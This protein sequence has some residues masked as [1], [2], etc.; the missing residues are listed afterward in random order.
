MSDDFIK[1]YNYFIIWLVEQ[2][3][4]FSYIPHSES[5]NATGGGGIPKCHAEIHSKNDFRLKFLKTDA[6]NF[7][8]NNFSLNFR[9]WTVILTRSRVSL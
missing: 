2:E 9:V 8:R 5:N 3:G 6:F 1:K 7:A 4:S